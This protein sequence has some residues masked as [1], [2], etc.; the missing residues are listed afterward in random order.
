MVIKRYKDDWSKSKSRELYRNVLRRTILKFRNPKDVKVAFFPGIDAAELYEVYDPLGIPRSNIVGFE[1][2]SQISQVLEADN[3]GIRIVQ[4][5]FEE[6]VEEQATISFDEVSLDYI[7]PLCVK[8][9]QAIKNLSAK[10]NKKHFVLHTSNLARRDHNSVGLYS[11]G[12]VIGQKLPVDIKPEEALEEIIDRSNNIIKKRRSGESLVIERS[13]GYS[14]IISAA[15]GAGDRAS[16][17]RLLQFLGGKL[18]GSLIHRFNEKALEF[19]GESFKIDPEDPVGSIMG[20][21]LFPAYQLLLEEIAL[22]RV[23]YVCT[24]KWLVD[25]RSHV[26]LLAAFSDVSAERKVFCRKDG[27]FYTYISESGAPMIGDISFLSYPERSM[28]Y[29][30]E[31]GRLAGYPHEFRIQGVQQMREILSVLIRYSRSNEIFQNLKEYESILDKIYN[32][33]FLGNSSKPVLTKRTAIEEFEGGA[34]VEDVQEKYRGWTN[35]PLAQWKAHVTMGTYR[36]KPIT[37]EED[38]DLEKITKEETLD[39]IASGIP[40]KEIQAAYPTSFSAGQLRSFKAH[41]SMGTYKENL[42]GK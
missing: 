12:Y 7:G 20:H 19:F 35:K 37:F 33:T 32:R 39:L 31:I 10:Q 14:K 40:I 2:E 4:K 38:K 13:Q 8:Q 6:W 42:K 25:K 34:S 28:V 41:I 21:N 16:F 22:E 5:P 26:A 9:V 1:K 27:E 36:K 3:L 18:Y 24:Q 23:N 15:L 29:A 11:Y 17:N 30:Q